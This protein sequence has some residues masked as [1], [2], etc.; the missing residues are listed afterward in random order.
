VANAFFLFIITGLSGS[1]G[2]RR[3]GDWKPGNYLTRILPKI[4]V[5]LH[6]CTGYGGEET[7]PTG[8]GS[9]KVKRHA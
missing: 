4:R 9:E 6:R 7:F 3:A 5:L 2:P 1:D 8:F